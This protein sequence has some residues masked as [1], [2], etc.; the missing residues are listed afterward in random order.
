M[1]KKVIISRTDSLGDVILTLPLTGYLK[2]VFP[3]I[4]ISFVGQAYSQSVINSCQ[5]VDTFYDKKKLLNGEQKLEGDVIIF[6]FP[7]KELCKLAKK[8]KIPVRVGTSHRIFHW[9]T[10]NKLVNFSRKKSELHESQL[11]FKLLKPLGVEEAPSLSEMPE[12]VGMR[13][14]AELPEVQKERLDTGKFNLILH[15]KSKGSAREWPL[16]HYEKLVEILPSEKFHFFVSGTQA[17]GDLIKNEGTSL[18]DFPNV[19]DVSGQFSLEEFISFIAQADGLVAC[20]TGPLHIAAMLG[21][22]ALGFYPSMRPMH[23][24]RWKALGAKVGIMEVDDV[25]GKGS[26][27]EAVEEI[28]PQMAADYILSHFS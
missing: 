13:A 25:L 28:S 26:G 17:E 24:G 1:L 2:K 6:A 12:L 27:S 21:K 16:S 7:D 9:G 5:Y 4:S 22:N 10:C 11:N 19:T 15:P 20:S 3:D 14:M 18:F 8:S 23:P